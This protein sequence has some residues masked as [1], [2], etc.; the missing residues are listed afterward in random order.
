MD[1]IRCVM[2]VLPSGREEKAEFIEATP[3]QL[4]CSM[5][6]CHPQQWPESRQK[7]ALRS[8]SAFAIEVWLFRYAFVFFLIALL[9]VFG[10]VAVHS[11][12][13]A[14]LFHHFGELLF[15]LII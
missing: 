2:L 4:C 10:A 13:G 14:V 1:P 11:H 5:Y 7:K 8:G 9:L 15:L 6:V 12:T 3:D